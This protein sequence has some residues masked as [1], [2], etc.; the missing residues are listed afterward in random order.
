MQDIIRRYVESWVV[1]STCTVFGGSI[2]DMHKYQVD[3]MDTVWALTEN[4][5]H[6]TGTIILTST[7]RR[8]RKRF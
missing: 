5:L 8:L 2:S 4:I 3:V 6:L 7:E 1:L